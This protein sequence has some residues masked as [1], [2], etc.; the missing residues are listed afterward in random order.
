MS[1]IDIVLN[2]IF[3]NPSLPTVPVYGFSDDFERSNGPVGVTSREAKPWTEHVYPGSDVQAVIDGGKLK[4]TGSTFWKVLAV[5]AKS[6][7]GTFRV[8]MSSIDVNGGLR[9]ALRVTNATNFLYVRFVAGGVI[10]LESLIGGTG[11]VI[12]SSAPI[13][14]FTNGVFETVLDGD[15]VSVKWNGIEVIPPQT[16]TSMS[17]NTQHGFMLR[18]ESPNTRVESA[19]FQVS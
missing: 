13:T 12:A 19:S 5:D 8:A 7:N 9:I 4:A 15:K 2:T 18:S 16:V 6:P 14:G 1:G 11:T 3:N 17:G 10:R